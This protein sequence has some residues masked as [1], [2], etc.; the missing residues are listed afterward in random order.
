MEVR[1]VRE[2]WQEFRLDAE[3]MDRIEPKERRES[4]PT[5]PKSRLV[6]ALKA[7]GYLILLSDATIDE[8]P[9]SIIVGTRISTSKVLESDVLEIAKSLG[10]EWFKPG[11]TYWMVPEG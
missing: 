7:K 5:F 6:N 4:L 8:I 3:E 1:Q 10:I 11:T 9:I 2:I